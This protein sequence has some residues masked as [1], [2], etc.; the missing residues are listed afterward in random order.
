MASPA[1]LTPRDQLNVSARAVDAPR[2]SPATRVRSTTSEVPA[3]EIR[4]GSS[5]LS[6][7]SA[8]P[9]RYECRSRWARRR[10]PPSRATAR[11]RCARRRIRRSSRRDGVRAS[12]TTRSAQALQ[13]AHEPGA[14]DQRGAD[15]LRTAPGRAWDIRRGDDAGPGSSTPAET[16]GGR[17]RGREPAATET[18]PSALVKEK[19]VS[20]VELS[21][22][23]PS[24]SPVSAAAPSERRRPTARAAR[25]A[26][27][28]ARCR[29]TPAIARRCG[30]HRGATACRR[31]VAVG[32]IDQAHAVALHRG[33][34]DEHAHLAQPLV[35]AERAGR[36]APDWPDRR[37]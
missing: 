4:S 6:R 35:R 21:S 20:A 24:P 12:V 30:R 17:C 36:G 25:R 2:V 3:T 13:L 29:R 15:A 11:T 33:D 16:A 5:N 23:M 18:R 10:S 32:R 28:A 1:G 8:R 22:T 34:A 31:A 9:P 26:G 7:R 19:C 14:V 27:A 37:C